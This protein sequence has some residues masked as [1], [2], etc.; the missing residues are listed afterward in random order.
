V[1]PRDP[2]QRVIDRQLRGVAGH[3]EEP[4]GQKYC[5]PLGT[6]EGEI[7]SAIDE[8]TSYGDYV[9]EW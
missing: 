9:E 7:L 4:P 1:D 8:K 3:W 2:I 5:H 6:L